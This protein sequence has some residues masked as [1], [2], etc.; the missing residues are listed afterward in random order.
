M[1]LLKTFLVAVDHHD[2]NT[3]ASDLMIIQYVLIKKL[4]IPEDA[5]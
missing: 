2:Y 3:C 5:T 4:D 1:F